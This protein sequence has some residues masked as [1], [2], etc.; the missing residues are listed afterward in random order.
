[1]LANN[2]T[3]STGHKSSGLNAD[4]LKLVWPNFLKS[5]IKRTPLQS[6][7][8]I[9]A[10]R[11]SG[12]LSGQDFDVP[13]RRNLTQLNFNHTQPVQL[14]DGSQLHDIVAKH[15]SRLNA[16]SSPGFDSKLASLLKHACKLVI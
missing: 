2:Y 16:T 13:L 4:L 5:C 10:R 12:T 8:N 3:E 14:A 6:Y 15:V 1:M 11:W 7:T 9:P